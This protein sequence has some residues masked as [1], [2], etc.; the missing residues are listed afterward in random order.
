VFT[1]HIFHTGFVKVMD[2]HG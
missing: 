2:Q 1:V